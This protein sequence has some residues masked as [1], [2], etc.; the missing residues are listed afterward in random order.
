[1]KGTS[2]W[3]NSE[4]SLEAASAKIGPDGYDIKM[5]SEMALMSAMYDADNCDERNIEQFQN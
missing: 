2:F 3:I 1:M 5:A 4:R